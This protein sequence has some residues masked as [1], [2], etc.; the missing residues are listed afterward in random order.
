VNTS[1]F[2]RYNGGNLVE[3][4]HKGKQTRIYRGYDSSE[5]RPVAIRVVRQEMTMRSIPRDFSFL[6]RLVH[7]HICRCYDANVQDS[8]NQFGELERTEALVMEFASGGDI[9]SYTSR[10]PEYRKKLLTDVL[11]GLEYL[12]ENGMVHGNLNSAQVLI[13]ETPEGPQALISCLEMHKT[14]KN[15][16]FLDYYAPEQLMPNA[17]SE[18]DHRADLWAWGC[19]VYEVYSGERLFMVQNSPMQTEDLLWKMGAEPY[20]LRTIP[21]QMR[22]YAAH[23]LKSNPERRINTV[24]ELLQLIRD[25][26]LQREK[27]VHQLQGKVSELVIVTKKESVPSRGKDLKKVSSKNP[28]SGLVN[29]FNAFRRF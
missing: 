13:K 28:P 29:F 19:M 1:F 26:D 9:I 10:H 24:T 22:E 27:E 7:P 8:V 15:S 25:N 11:K 20:D 23:C 17:Y 14:K 21:V 12:H 3:L 4:I 6:S 18:Y 5:L 16:S 2:T